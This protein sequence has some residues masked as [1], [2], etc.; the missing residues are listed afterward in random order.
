[1]PVL[2]LS[3]A[4]VSLAAAILAVAGCGDSSGLSPQHFRFTLA[5]DLEGWTV[6][7][8]D[9]PVGT[10]DA[11]QQA[12]DE[13]FELDGGHAHL[14]Q[15]LDTGDGAVLLTGNN[16]S[17]DLFMFLKRRVSGLAPDTTYQLELRVVFATNVPRGCF[18]IGGSP[19][20]SVYVKGGAT[21]IEPRRFSDDTSG[22][23]VW[24]MNIDKGQQ[25]SGGIDAVV[26]GDFANSKDCESADFSY[27]LKELS[28]LELSAFDVTTNGNG[29]AWLLLGTDSG[30]EGT[31]TIYYTEIEATVID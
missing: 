31:T 28:N 22:H 26:L 1:M 16:H 23:L 13:F 18:G 8:A 30:F 7:F 4:K 9:Y 5:E 21:G 11:E 29:E 10:S 15:P 19:G 14:P 20:D 17:D 25:A 2:P 27:E 3:T 6:G 12:I 24:S